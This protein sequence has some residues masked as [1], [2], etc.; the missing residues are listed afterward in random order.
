MKVVYCIP[1]QCFAAVSGH[2]ASIEMA[3]RIMPCATIAVWTRPPL[4]LPTCNR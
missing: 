1:V 3:S 2:V 4:C